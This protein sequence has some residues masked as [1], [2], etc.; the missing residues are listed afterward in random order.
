M[1][2]SAL[3]V[4]LL[5]LIQPSNADSVVANP[6]DAQIEAVLSAEIE[7]LSSYAERAKEGFCVGVSSGGPYSDPPVA[8]LK[9]LKR[10]LPRVRAASACSGQPVTVAGPF[11]WK[12]GR[13]LASGGDWD[14]VGRCYYHVTLKLFRGWRA[15]YQPCPLE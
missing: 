15:T 3:G 14:I 10:T 8:V 5:A 12:D 6:S 11:W 1:I 4:L 9:R 13:L 7:R 2:V